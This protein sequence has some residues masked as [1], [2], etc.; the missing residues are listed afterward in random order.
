MFGKVLQRASVMHRGPRRV[1]RLR[2]VLRSLAR[3]RLQIRWPSGLDSRD[4]LLDRLQGSRRL[5][6]L[7]LRL[8]WL[9]RML[10]LLMLLHHRQ[11]SQ[12]V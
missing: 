6:L 11:L 2:L 12:R 5:L 1:A 9:L 7:L 3:G 10:L 8:L 4:H